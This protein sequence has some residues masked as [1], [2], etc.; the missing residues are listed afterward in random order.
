MTLTKFLRIFTYKMA[1]KN[2]TGID[3]EQNYVI[4]TL[5]MLTI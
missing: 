3:R 2:S 5:R 1:A 4:V